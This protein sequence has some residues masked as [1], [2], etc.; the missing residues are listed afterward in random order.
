MKIFNIHQREYESP[1]TVLAEIFATL[2][3]K[4]D[5]L[6]PN[7]SWP[8][9]VLS[10]GLNLHSSGGH[11]PIGYYVSNHDPRKS[12]QFTFTKPEGFVGSHTFE[13]IA[14]GDKKTV[15]RH[16][17][18]MSLNLK[19]IITWYIAIKWLHDAL[20]EDCLD[21][22]H[23]QV[24]RSA[25]HSPHNLWVKILRKVLGRRRKAV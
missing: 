18:N 19:G 2:S 20:L 7:E 15:L 9:M 17:I 6:W 22:V 24:A 23:N 21:K 14:I 13:I 8:P 11:G 1:P 3:S 5:R 12:V 25:V 10:N 16:T 4:N